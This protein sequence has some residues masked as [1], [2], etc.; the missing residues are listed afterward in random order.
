VTDAVTLPAIPRLV[1]IGGGSH[2]RAG[3]TVVPLDGAGEGDR[4][5]DRGSLVAV[6]RAV[7]PPAF[8]D[9]VEAHRAMVYRF[10][11]AAVGPHDADDCFQ[12]TFLSALRAYPRLV[13][14]EHLDRWV[15]RIASRKALD[16]HRARRRAPVPTGSVPERVASPADPADA[17]DPLWEAVRVLPPRQRIA[18]VQRHVLDRS[19]AEVAAAMG[20]TEEAARANVYQGIK[21]LRGMTWNRKS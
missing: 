3:P 15:L 18:V 20:G 9:F 8:R 12:E 10:L 7:S 5:P 16:H 17:A 4:V 2:G 11:L 19:Y 6:R 14:G 13:D 1:E 21:R